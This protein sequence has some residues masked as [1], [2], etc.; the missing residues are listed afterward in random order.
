M[1]LWKS[2]PG[3]AYGVAHRFPGKRLDL[4]FLIAVGA[5]PGLLL[6]GLVPP[7]LVL[8][9]LSIVSFTV[10]AFVALWAYRRGADRHADGMTFWDVAGF[11]AVIWVGA[12]MLSTPEHVV[13]LFDH[14]TMTR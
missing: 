9:A 2:E 1:T 10:A 12:G 5:A 13:A 6:V 7:Q 4:P 14:M 3:S 11:L 8:P